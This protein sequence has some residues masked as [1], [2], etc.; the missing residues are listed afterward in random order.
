MKCSR[1]GG[2]D[3]GCYVCRTEPADE[4]PAEPDS[5][6]DQTEEEE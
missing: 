4:A 3:P 2:A 5:R 1:C 6:E